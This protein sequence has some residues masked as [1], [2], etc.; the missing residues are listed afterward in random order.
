MTVP[1]GE[2]VGRR[3]P[4]AILQE[5][6]A[7]HGAIRQQVE[8]LRA[9]LRAPEADRL[10]QKLSSLHVAVA[11]HNRREEELLGA[12]LPEVDAWGRV[13]AA[14]MDAAHR[15]EHGELER[16]LLA[17]S[18][19]EPDSIKVVLDALIAHLREEERTFLNDRV[20]THSP[21][22]MEQSDG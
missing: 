1:S 22:V 21:V 15:G 10:D 18:G 19:V 16:A 5:L 6:S 9:A 11:A 8:D 13:R 7:Q 12:I 20:L 17:R 4:G 14:R 2:H 3:A